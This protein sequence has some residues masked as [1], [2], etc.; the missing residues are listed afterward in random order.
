[1]KVLH[2]VRIL[3]FSKT[4]SVTR[5][6]LVKPFP[7]REWSWRPLEGRIRLK[8]QFHQA[9]QREVHEKIGIEHGSIIDLHHYSMVTMGEEELVD[10]DYG[11][12]IEFLSP[13]SMNQKTRAS[14]ADIRWMN[15]FQA[16]KSVESKPVAEALMRLELE[17][18][19]PFD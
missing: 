12:R 5:H 13:E 7:R 10:W 14:F 9:I 1:M 16:L 18:Q 3:V 19:K 17:L 15:L 11:Y 8:E 4:G 2:R 6:L